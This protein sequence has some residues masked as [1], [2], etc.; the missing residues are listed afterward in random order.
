MS[1]GNKWVAPINKFGQLLALGCALLVS[2]GVR[3]Q[4][5]DSWASPLYLQHELVGKIWH[6][7]SKSFVTP[8]ELNSAILASRIVMLGEKHDNP[9]HHALQMVLLKFMQSTGSLASVSFEMLDSTAREGAGSLLGNASLDDAQLR[10]ILN[11]DE[12]GWRWDHYGPMLRFLVDESVPVIPA[13]ISRQEMSEVYA[14]E[15]SPEIVGVLNEQQQQ[16][17]EIDIDESHCGMLPTSQFPA[18]IRVQ[19]A[20]D[21]SMARSLQSAS[22]DGMTVL[23]AGNYHARRDLGVSNYL[24]AQN[25]GL[26]CEDI[27]AIS[28]MEVQPDVTNPEEYLDAVGSVPAYDYIWFTPAV[29]NEDYCASLRPSTN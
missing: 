19:Q 22:V 7:K 2:T 25:V 12:A 26:E 9:D 14:S 23:I 16:R 17:L 13:N 4:P 6:S 1:N 3:S 28:F 10:A 21:D 11:W 15:L 18:M 8:A 24:L 27:L 5:I 29:T 20:R